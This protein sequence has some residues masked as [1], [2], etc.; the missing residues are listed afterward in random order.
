MGSSVTDVVAVCPAIMGSS[1][2][3]VVAVCPAVMETSPAEVVAIMRPS[4]AEVVDD[5]PH[6]NLMWWLFAPAVMRSS[7]EVVVVCL[8]CNGI[9]TGYL[10]PL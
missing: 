8:R 1:V 7:A 2:A 5:C 6:C 4:V 9:F 10:A 3:E